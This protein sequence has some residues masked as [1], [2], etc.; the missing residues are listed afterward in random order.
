[1]I[2]IRPLKSTIFMAAVSGISSVTLLPVEEI[3]PRITIAKR[4]LR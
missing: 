2:E 4:P 3:I 1:M